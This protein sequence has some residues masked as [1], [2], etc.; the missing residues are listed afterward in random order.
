MNGKS[1]VL[2]CKKKKKK[3]RTTCYAV[4]NMYNPPAPVWC[5]RELHDFS[6]NII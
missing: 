2:S 6:D 3:E 1:G 4:V 5:K